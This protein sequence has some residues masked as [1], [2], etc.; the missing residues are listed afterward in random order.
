MNQFTKSAIVA[1]VA[2]AAVAA[3]PPPVP[4][5]PPP[6]AS[7]SDPGLPVPTN[8]PEQIAPPARLHLVAPARAE[9]S[10]DNWARATA[11]MRRE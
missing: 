3:A 6:M 9:T 11:A 4:A 2:L 5:I 8:P 7:H 1:S 10:I